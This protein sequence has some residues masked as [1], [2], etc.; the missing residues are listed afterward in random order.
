MYLTTIICLHFETNDNNKLFN[1][2]ISFN[3]LR[4]M[5]GMTDKLF[6]S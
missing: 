6:S 5:S 1:I 4:I 2:N 3:L